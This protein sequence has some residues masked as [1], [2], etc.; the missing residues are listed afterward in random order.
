MELQSEMERCLAAMLMDDLSFYRDSPK[1][2]G[3][4]SLI[5]L[6]LIRYT[7]RCTV[8]KLSDMLDLDKSTVSRKVES[9]VRE[10]LV[11]KRKDDGDGRVTCWDS[12]PTWRSSTTGTTSRTTA[13]STGSARNWDR[14]GLAPCAAP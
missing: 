13:Q 6:N 3:Y 1:D 9:L 2:I 4:Q 8:G 7:D 12:A 5:Y 10:G 14:T 11:V